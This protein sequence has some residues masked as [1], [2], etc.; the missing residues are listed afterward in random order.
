M[1]NLTAD[2]THETRPRG[3][4]RSY[5]VLSGATLFAGSLVGADAAGFLAKWADTVG[6]E[7][8]GLLLAGAVGDGTVKGR[9]DCS[10]KTIME[11]TVGSLV[12]ASVNALVYCATDN[13]AD[14]SLS[15]ATNVNAVGWVSRYNS[16][17]VGE[18]TLFTPEEHLALN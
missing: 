2:T 10:G 13:P 15:A 7:F 5:T 6:H 1:A 18:V 17:G 4:V 8:Q 16:A 14:F 11:A 12:Q 3:G 9:V